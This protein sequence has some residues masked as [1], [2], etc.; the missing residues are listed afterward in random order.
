GR[1]STIERT[2]AF[3]KDTNPDKRSKLID[4]LL[5]DSEYGEHFATIWYHA[6]VKPDDDNRQLISDSF[7][8]WLADGFNKNH[9][10][11]KMVSDILTAEG[12][13]DK[14]PATVFFF[15]NV[16]ADRDKHPEANKVTAAASHLFLG[17]KLECC[18]CH[19]HPFSTLKQT[20]FWGVAAFFG[21]THSDNADKK[22]VKAGAIPSIHEGG[23]LKGKAA[24]LAKTESA[25]AGSIVIPD[26]KGKTVKAKY[27]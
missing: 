14:N 20:D 25:P 8:H 12:A 2:I 23:A 5:A 10:W 1:I 24:K 26:T 13:R 21:H 9:G 6:M 27:L 17:V 16:G 7:A 3:L 19:N 18:E 22:S 4:E 15:A 11:N